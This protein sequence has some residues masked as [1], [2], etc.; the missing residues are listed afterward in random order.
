MKHVRERERESK[1]DKMA[2]QLLGFVHQRTILMNHWK[3]DIKT[4]SIIFHRYCRDPDTVQQ[5][6]FEDINRNGI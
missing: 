2:I 3:L 5:N 1:E 6:L 4:S